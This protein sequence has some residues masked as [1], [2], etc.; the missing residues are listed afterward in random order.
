VRLD[1][2]PG[3]APFWNIFRQS[4]LIERYWSKLGTLGT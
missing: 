1:V 3:F 2:Y 4:R